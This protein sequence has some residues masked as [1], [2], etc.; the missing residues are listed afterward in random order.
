MLVATLN[1]TVPLPVPL[2]RPV[3]ES[4]DAS[5]LADHTHDDAAA[6]A[7]E[8]LFVPDAPN[9]TSF[10]VTVTLQVVGGPRD[11]GPGSIDA[12]CVTL[13]VWPATAMEA[14]RVVVPVFGTAVKLTLPDPVPVVPSVSVTQAASVCALHA[15]PAA[16]VT[17]KLPLPPAAGTVCSVVESTKRQA[18]AS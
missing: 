12:C 17:E 2:V 5:E 9:V 15:Q 13:T 18:A 7:I 1:V 6:T 11:G 3:S 14:A 16:A 10:G 4:H 8:L